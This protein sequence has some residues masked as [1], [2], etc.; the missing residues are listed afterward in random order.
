[1]L[2]FCA[3]EVAAGGSWS[4]DGLEYI[5]RP[6]YEKKN[7]FD[8]VCMHVQKKKKTNTFCITN[9]PSP[10]QQI[11]C[12]NTIGKRINPPTLLASAIYSQGDSLT[13][14]LVAFVGARTGVTRVDPKCCA[15]SLNLTRLNR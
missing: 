14:L 13:W 4:I 10:K 15:T 6:C 8:S 11:D 1:M 5:C 2:E 12:A 3:D 9:P 7:C